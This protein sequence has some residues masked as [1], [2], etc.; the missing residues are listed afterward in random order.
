MDANRVQEQ[1]K[2]LVNKLLSG[3]PADVS[4]AVNQYFKASF[5][6]AALRTSHVDIHGADRI[7]QLGRLSGLIRSKKGKIV[8]APKF[9]EKSK[10]VRYSATLP[11]TSPRL[12]SYIPL[13]AQL[14]GFQ[15]AVEWQF[16]AH[17]TADDGEGKKLYVAKL[18]AKRCNP[19]LIDNAIPAWILRPLVTYLTLFIVSFMAF[20]QSHKGESAGSF[21]MAAVVE[22]I[23]T[24]WS[25]I[26]PE[27]GRRQEQADKW[28]EEKVPQIKQ[29][30]QNAS[31]QA[32]DT[33]SKVQAD[34][35]S[36]AKSAG[37]PV[38]DYKQ[39]TTQAIADLANNVEAR[40][41]AAGVPVDEYKKQAEAAIE[42]LKKRAGEMGEFIEGKAGEAKEGARDVAK[43]AQKKVDGAK[44]GK[45]DKRTRENSNQLSQDQPAPSPT[46]A[47]T[48]SVTGEQAGHL[49]E[50]D[51]RAKE[52]QAEFEQ[53]PRTPLGGH[54]PTAPNAPSFAAA[55]AL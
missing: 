45:Q 11:Y 9:D 55:A 16:V 51:Q 10:T 3:D 15:T 44:Q 26:A 1:S 23:N 4:D 17:L 7:K 24:M 37:I 53:T 14:S 8:E 48:V 18:E 38:D 50:N 52:I 5:S 21:A 33:A 35:E 39:R 43:D 41:K 6:D 46:H 25:F 54:D 34:L 28:R 31:S 12:P 30:I 2:E 42:E 32:L 36:R 20:Y 29:Y 49:S 47:P 19:S 13:S 27:V 40:A 22:V